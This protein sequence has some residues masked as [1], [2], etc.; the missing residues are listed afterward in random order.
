MLSFAIA[1]A[2]RLMKNRAYTMPQS[3]KEALRGWL[4]L[5]P[6]NEWFEARI[7]PCETE[8]YDGWRRGLATCLL[9]SKNG[10]SSRAVPKG[11]LPPVNTFSQRLKAM[12]NVM[13]KRTAKGSVAMGVEVLGWFD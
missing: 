3:S 10:R 8:P 1:G 9:T 13:V 2:Q 4:L 12:P 11:F 6:V 7:E 5:D